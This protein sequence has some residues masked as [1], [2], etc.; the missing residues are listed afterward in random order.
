MDED[1]RMGKIYRLEAKSLY[2]KIPD[3]RDRKAA[4]D[5]FE[6]WDDCAE[7]AWD[8]HRWDR[9]S[10]TQND[11]EGLLEQLTKLFDLAH[12]YGVKLGFPFPKY[13]PRAAANVIKEPQQAQQEQKQEQRAAIAMPPPP[14]RRKIPTSIEAP[15]KPSSP[16]SQRT[17]SV[18]GVVSRLPSTALLNDVGIGLVSDDDSK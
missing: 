10:R 1:S 11:G 13:R 16:G 4:K 9:P 6:L 15:P 8:R 12:K 5:A 2:K 7:N 3:P 14:P 17:A 18:A